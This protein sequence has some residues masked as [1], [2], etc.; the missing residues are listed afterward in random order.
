MSNFFLYMFGSFG[1]FFIGILG[2][3]VNRSRNLK[4]QSVFL[5]IT[6]SCIAFFSFGN[7]FE[8][9]E[10][11]PLFASLILIVFLFIFISSVII[12]SKSGYGQNADESEKTWQLSFYLHFLFYR[13]YWW[14]IICY[15]ISAVKTVMC[16][17][18]LLF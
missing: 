8:H 3:I 12:F 1:L 7:R 17:H 15:R 18:C 13:L 14:L 6:G 10:Y 2:C 11:L 9:S 4:S 16:I 5:I